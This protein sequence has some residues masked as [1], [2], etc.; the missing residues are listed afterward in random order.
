MRVLYERNAGV[1]AKLKES[2][3]GFALMEQMTLQE[4][5]AHLETL[6]ASKELLAFLSADFELRDDLYKALA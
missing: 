3:L 1:N 4:T 5:L 2:T 6:G